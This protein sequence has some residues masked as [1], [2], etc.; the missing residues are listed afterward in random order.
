MHASPLASLLATAAGAETDRAGR[1]K[2]LPNCTLPDHPEVFVVGDLMALDHLPGV[3]EVAM[4][5]GI[6]AALTIKRRLDG[7]EDNDF[8]YRDLG[9]MATVARFRA[10][11]DFRGLRVG[12]IVGWLMWLVVHLTFM[13]GFK[14]RFSALFHWAVT[15]LSGGR[16]QRTITLREVTARVALDEAS[17]VQSE[18]R[19]ASEA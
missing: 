11:V 12:G 5:S 3:A 16:A 7:E 10:I 14:N 18:N 19:R 15:F 2:V 8:T 6:H 17:R 4:Q 13:T 9:S 1:V